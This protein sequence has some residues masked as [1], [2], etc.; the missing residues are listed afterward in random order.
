LV[1]GFFLPG[2]WGKAGMLQLPFPLQLQLPL[3][4]P[5]PLQ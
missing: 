4:L 5:L 3:P 2:S 1:A